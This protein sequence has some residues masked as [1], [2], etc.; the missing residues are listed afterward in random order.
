M[1]LRICA[2][3]LAASLAACTTIPSGP[4]LYA[5]PGT[6]KNFDQFRYDDQDCRQYAQVQTGGTAPE[7]LLS[8]H[9]RRY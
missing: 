5:L 6:G 7:I 3:A 2:A 9:R 1:K 8:A 4:S